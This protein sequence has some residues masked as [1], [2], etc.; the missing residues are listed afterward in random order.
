MNNI[1]EKLL[2]VNRILCDN[3]Q[4]LDF[5]GRD[6]VSQNLLSN[7]RTFVEHIALKI[8]SDR[9]E[10]NVDY[11]GIKLALENL[12]SDYKFLFLRKFHFF[13]QQT[14][15][16]YVPDYD[17][18]ERLL[19]KYYKYLLQIKNFL[20]ERYD[21]E[22]LYNIDLFPINTDKTLLEYYTKIADRL[23]VTTMNADYGKTTERFYIQKSKPFFVNDKIYYENT[24]SLAN[25][26]ASK[27]NRFVAFSTFEIPSNYAIKVLLKD[28]EITIGNRNMPVK[29][30]T[31]WTISIRPCELKNF[32]KIFGNRIDVRSDSLE[33]N[34]IMNFLTRTGMSL[35]EVIETSDDN[36]ERIKDKMIGKAQS[37]K[38]IESLEECRSLVLSNSNGCNVLRYLLYRLNNKSIRLQYDTRDNSFL[39][40]LRLSYGCIPFDKMPFA[41]SLIGHNPY[42][43]D[44]FGCINAKGREHELLARHVNNNASN[45]GQLY[46]KLED[47]EKYGDVGSLINIFNGKLYRNIRHQKRRLEVVG[48]N[49]FVKGHEEDIS[50]IISKLLAL[51]D[52]GLGGYKESVEAWLQSHTNIDCVEKEEIIKVMFESSKIA[53]IYGAAGTGKTYLINHVSQFFDD[54]DKLYLAHTNPA[55][56]N[57]KRRVSSKNCEF[58]TITKFL[59]SSRVETKYNI[60]FIDECSI[61]SNED[62]LNILNKV[63]CK[64]LV[65]VGDVY[66]IESIEFGN[67]F[68]LARYFIPY[69]SMY[70]LTTPHRTKNN[71]LLVLWKK[72]RDME[73][74]LTEHIVN[75]G[76]STTLDET[77]FEMSAQ[78]EI[79]LCLNYDG[80][81]GINNIN[82]FLQNNNPKPPINW[83]VW[84]YKVGDPI[85]FNE[86][87]R[88]GTVL[89]NNLKGKIVD[90]LV[91]EDKIT[92]SIEIDRALT[93][94]DTDELDIKLLKSTTPGKS[95]VQITVIKATNTDEDDEDSE[96]IVPFQ[97]AYAVSIHKAQ[98]L[99]YDSVKVVI[100]EEIDKMITHNIFY[101]AITRSKDKLK[102]YW[103][104]ESQ[105]RV[106]T[107]LKRVESRYDAVVLS[108]RSG[109]KRQK[110]LH[111]KT[112]R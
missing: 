50:S 106:I 96:A 38:F 61:V 71:E 5:L 79:I 102:I 6:L 44:V 27:F 36:Y 48:D 12:K 24:L 15:S 89:Y 9:Y 20:K 2:N 87:E 68:S 95:V 93:E 75:Q 51:T 83:G 8:Y 88:F 67:W 100:T 69:T 97:I 58:M 22:V 16:H 63:E 86:S 57:L 66:Q 32:A 64:L 56:E 109:L 23:A 101:T 37:V 18:A 72:V 74:D 34:G 40:E 39:S 62:I 4:A 77:I 105:Q 82:R 103:T 76:Y 104:P 55:V 10:C 3:I 17:G 29:L 78:D 31:Q 92:F 65:L 60:L 7:L 42:I 81:Y 26:S 99:E 59:M 80:L 11:D 108:A 112:S 21:M 49:I 28:D 33:Y 73:D 111:T 94:L 70:E 43:S 25:D 52:E 41:S 13:L 45:N 47:V 84:T 91:A 107:N 110:N 98:G 1:D 90:I 53:M 14:V 19:L 30:I 54:I 85:L 35:V 46:T